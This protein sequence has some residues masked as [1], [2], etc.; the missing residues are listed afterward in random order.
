MFA[1]HRNDF[2]CAASGRV[3]LLEARLRLRYYMCAHLDRTKRFRAAMTRNIQR[4]DLKGCRG[5]SRKGARRLL[6]A[7]VCLDYRQATM[8]HSYS[9]FSIRKHPNQAQKRGRLALA[10]LAR[11]T[12]TPAYHQLYFAI[13]GLRTTVIFDIWVCSGMLLGTCYRR[14]QTCRACLKRPD[15]SQCAPTPRSLSQLPRSQDCYT[16]HYLPSTRLR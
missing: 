4:R 5:Y 9:T 10:T 15:L 8:L 3:F 16:L 2:G 12:S 13:H 14:C 6:R 1:T 11:S 7:A